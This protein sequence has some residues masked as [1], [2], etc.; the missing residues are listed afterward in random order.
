MSEELEK[1]QE[2]RKAFEQEFGRFADLR[3]DAATGADPE[4]LLR[5]LGELK[6]RHTGKKSAISG[7]MNLVGKVDVDKRAEFGRFVQSVRQTITENIEKAEAKLAAVIA[8]TKVERERL[9]VTIP[10]RRP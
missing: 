4:A 6:V 2:I 7:A 5:E 8:Y 10:G 3:L 9:D 1:V